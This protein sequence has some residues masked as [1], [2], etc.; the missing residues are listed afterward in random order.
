MWNVMKGEGGVS[1][2]FTVKEMSLFVVLNN[3]EVDCQSA[4]PGS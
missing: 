1:G 3:C 2:F 4:A